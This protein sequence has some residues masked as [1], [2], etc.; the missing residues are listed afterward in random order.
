MVRPGSRRRVAGN[1]GEMAS[2]SHSATR[3][4]SP[5]GHGDAQETRLG[6]VMLTASRGEP[7]GPRTERVFGIND[8]GKDVAGYN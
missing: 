2:E 6:T 1:P 8:Y 4:S 3:P 5:E 7:Q